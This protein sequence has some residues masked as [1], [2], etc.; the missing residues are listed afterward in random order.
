[1]KSLAAMGNVDAMYTLGGN[2]LYGIG[3]D[4]DLEQAHSYLEKAAEKG[5]TAATDLMKNIF[6]DDWKSTEL[7][8]DF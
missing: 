4:V 6:A 1:M 2:Y 5:L 8:L 7:E 3:V